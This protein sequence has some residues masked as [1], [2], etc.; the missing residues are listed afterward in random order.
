MANMLSKITARDITNEFNREL[1][2]DPNHNYDVL[3]NHITELK[4]TIYQTDTKNSTN[5]GIK[6]EWITYGILRSFRF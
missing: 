3:H 4:D 5:I 1:I 2:S 6:N